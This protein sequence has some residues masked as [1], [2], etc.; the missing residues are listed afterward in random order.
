MKSACFVFLTL[1]SVLHSSSSFR[2]RKTILQNI[3]AKI[4]IASSLVIGP[5]NSFGDS[6]VSISSISVP[7]NGESVSI[8]KYLG[9][10]ATLIVNINSQCDVPADGDPQCNGLA[11]LFKKHSEE[12]FQILAFPS[13]QFRDK[14]M[15]GESE[16]IIEVRKELLEDYGWTFPVFDFV[17]VNGGNTAEIFK[18]MKDIKSINP[19][20]LK[21]INWNYEKFLVDKVGVPVRR[22]RP[23]TMPAQLDKDIQDLIQTG[24]LKPRAKAS[25]G[26]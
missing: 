25:L 6:A 26:A 16:P 7:Y 8:G 24:K 22:Y 14:S 21:K 20:D 15:L 18:V 12:G 9:S 3:F 19:S 11:K 10:K 2:P 1:L 5:C 13:D 17:E 23:S 4:C